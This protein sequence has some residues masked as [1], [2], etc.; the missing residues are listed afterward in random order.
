MATIHS[1]VFE[2]NLDGL[3]NI[4]FIEHS[5][6]IT[7]GQPYDGVRCYNACH[8]EPAKLV[9]LAGRKGS[10]EVSNWL[11]SNVNWPKEN[12]LGGA[13]ADTYMDD[14][15]RKLNFAIRGC[16]ILTIF[17][18]EYTIEDIVLA[19]GKSGAYNNWWLGSSSMIKIKAENMTDSY[20]Q[21]LSEMANKLI[22]AGLSKS[23]ARAINAI[24][25]GIY[26]LTKPHKVGRC[27]IGCT[28]DQFDKSK[29]V[30]FI[31]MKNSSADATMMGTYALDSEKL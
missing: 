19:Q 21:E 11:V 20:A 3:T 18:I 8:K 29:S 2:F 10:H 26:K 22:M 15:P 9:V 27:L 13:I 17:G 7:H 23:F 14:I 6:C 24:G 12:G 30:V 4:N 25:I 31:S 16:I 5:H 28:N 1:N